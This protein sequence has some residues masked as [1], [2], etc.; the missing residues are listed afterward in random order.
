[1]AFVRPLTAADAAAFRDIR[2]AGLADEPRAFSADWSEEVRHNL[3]WFAARIVS[4]EV[5][6]IGDDSSSLLAITGLSIPTNPKQ[7]HKGHI[8]GVYV[9]PEA[10]GRGFATTLLAAAITAARGRVEVLH[11]GVGTYND[12]ARRC[13]RAAGFVETGFEPRALRIGDD[14]VDEITMTL[15]LG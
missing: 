1:M 11:L 9:R 12:A 3:G 4:S 14:F 13:Y 8:W 5:F 2:L 10:R 15:R 6:A 7:R